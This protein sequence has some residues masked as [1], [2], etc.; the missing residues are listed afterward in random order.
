[1][2]WLTVTYIYE[3]TFPYHLHMAYVSLTWFD[4]QELL[5]DSICKSM[6]YIQSVFKSDRLL[7]DKLV[8]K[9]FLQSRLM[10]AFRKFY[11]RYN[12]L[13]NNYKLSLSQMLSGIFHTNSYTVIDTLTLTADNFAFMIKKLRSRR[14]WPVNKGC[15]LLLGTWP[16]IRYV[17]RYV[18]AHFFLRLVIHT[19]HCFFLSERQ[20]CR[21]ERP[22]TTCKFQY[23]LDRGFNYTRGQAF[24]LIL[25]LDWNYM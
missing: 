22:S 10:S 16:H 14:V 18:F 25:I 5:P 8:L 1:M 21:A 15:L 13:I 23:P 3:A 2:K 19:D 20:R 12:Y 9:G 4:M 24:I 7:T 17:R 11:G 6:L